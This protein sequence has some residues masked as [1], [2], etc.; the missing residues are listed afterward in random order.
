VPYRIIRR[1]QPLTGEP[2]L[3]LPQDTAV[4]LSLSLVPT[5]PPFPPF[6]NLDV[7][8]SPGG[9][10]NGAAGQGKMCWWV[11]DTAKTAYEGTPTLITVYGRTGLIAAHAANCDSLGNPG[12]GGYYSFMRDGLNSGM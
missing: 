9:P 10:V 4:D 3:Q 2:V 12:L 7:V 6:T 5:F 8:F 11:R 1:S